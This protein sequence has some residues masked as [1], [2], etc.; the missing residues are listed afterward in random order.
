VASS[1]LRSSCREPFEYSCSCPDHLC[2]LPTP[3]RTHP[4]GRVA[5]LTSF[6]NGLEP[7]VRARQQASRVRRGC[8][9]QHRRQWSFHANGRSAVHSASDYA[10]ILRSSCEVGDSTARFSV[11]SGQEGTRGMRYMWE[12]P[13]PI[14]ATGQAVGLL[15]GM[16][17]GLGGHSSLQPGGDGLIYERGE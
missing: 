4:Q 8:W 17:G 7:F 16:G 15:H 1:A 6:L 9:G 10:R 2:Y 11:G 14:A 13:W 5:D 3:N 12:Q